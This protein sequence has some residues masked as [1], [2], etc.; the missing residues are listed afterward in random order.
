MTHTLLT[1][2]QQYSPLRRA[3]VETGKATIATLASRGEPYDTEAQALQ[4]GC[5]TFRAKNVI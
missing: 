3:P 5:F 1:A 4:C 2:F